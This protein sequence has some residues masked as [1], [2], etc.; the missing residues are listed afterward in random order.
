MIQVK[1]MLLAEKLIDEWNMARYFFSVRLYFHELKV[2]E[3]IIVL[4]MIE[5]SRHI[6]Q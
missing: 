2:S 6:P 1:R 3:N 5:T 4:I